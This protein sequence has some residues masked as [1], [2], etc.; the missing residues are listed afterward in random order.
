MAEAQSQ[1]PGIANWSN[2][3]TK[4]T[5]FMSQLKPG[6]GCTLDGAAPDNKA[7]E[8]GGLRARGRVE[9]WNRGVSKTGE[10]QGGRGTGRARKCL[11]V[12]EDTKRD[13]K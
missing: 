10:E 11:R 3:K 2:G 4:Q 13:R 8:R 12:T 7:V 1:F 6:M 9:G 5:L